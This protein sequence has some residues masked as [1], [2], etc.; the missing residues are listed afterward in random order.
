MK[1]KIISLLMV[2]VLFST[3]VA[4]PVFAEEDAQ[5]IVDEEEVVIDDNIVT[6]ESTG[7]ELYA[8]DTDASATAQDVTVNYDSGRVNLAGG[9][10]ADAGSGISD[11]T[12]YV[13]VDNVNVTTKD[14]RETVGIQAYSQ[15]GGN[16]IVEAAGVT[17]NSDAAVVPGFNVLTVGV[18]ATTKNGVAVAVVND[19][20]NVTGA[21]G[22]TVGIKSVAGG[23]DGVSG[24]FSNGNINV[25]SQDESA[26]VYVVGKNGGSAGVIFGDGESA[27]MTVRS[28]QMARSL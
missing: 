5:V 10:C 26:G 12:A 13:G 4:L 7:L 23:N 22:L 25:T 8:V 16:A 6:N 11:V 19:D 27:E 21:E 24:V 2:S 15:N 20:V 28:K 18:D 14:T 9:A 1:K 3:T 17:V